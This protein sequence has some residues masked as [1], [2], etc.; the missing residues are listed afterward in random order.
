M[1]KSTVAQIRNR[2]D[3]DV[4]RFSNLETG[5]TAVM[6]TLLLLDVV[7][8]AAA[9]INPQASHVLDVGCG[10]GNFTMRLL[11]KL[12]NLNVTLVDLS[13]PMLERAKSRVAKVTSGQVDTQQSDIRELTLPTAQ[14][15]VILAGSV[16]H[17]LRTDTEWQAV[18]DKF[19]AALKP[20]G[21][22][23]VSDLIE[24]DLPQI[25]ALMWARY[26]DYLVDFQDEAYRDK[27]YSYIEQEDT[28]K[29]VLYQID[30]IRQ[31]GFSQV[32]ILH[33]NSCFAAFGGVK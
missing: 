17:H 7:T 3:N 12:P 5:Q 1:T 6:D 4:D 9:Q 22:V 31:A 29:S 2:F 30:R 20:G 25:Q 27:V 21:S 28:P 33:K 16:L 32:E 26:G 8:G 23:W 10:G 11:Q 19:H 15:D 24:H 18:F 14:F 13:A